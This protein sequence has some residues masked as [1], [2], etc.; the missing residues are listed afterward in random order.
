M[1]NKEV[2]NLVKELEAQGFEVT[3]AKG[4]HL[5]VYLDGKLITA[6]AST[7]SDIRSLANSIAFLRRNGFVY[8]GH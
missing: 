6:M 2:K 1:A 7:P 8:K 4:N 5:K 3:R